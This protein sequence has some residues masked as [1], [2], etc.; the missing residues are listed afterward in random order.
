MILD[1]WGPSA[2][3][4]FRSLDPLQYERE[5]LRVCANFNLEIHDPALKFRLVR[6]FCRCISEVRWIEIVILWVQVPIPTAWLVI[7]T[8]L[9][10]RQDSRFLLLLK[11]K[12]KV[13]FA[14]VLRSHYSQFLLF[15]ESPMMSSNF[16]NR[17]VI[18]QHLV[19]HVD[20]QKRFQRY[21]ILS[22]VSQ[23]SNLATKLSWTRGNKSLMRNVRTS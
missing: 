19:E 15:S 23:H 11:S 16:L 20:N 13:S 12:V 3:W 17:C 1:W 2:R 9:I 5:I 8:R 7:D 6:E 21:Y 22:C 4:L 18:H 10:Y 14:M